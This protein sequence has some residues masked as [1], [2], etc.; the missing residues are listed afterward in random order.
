MKRNRTIRLLR[1]SQTLLSNALTV[2]QELHRVAEAGET[3]EAAP[4]SAATPSTRSLDRS[5]T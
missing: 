5:G 1:A 2:V 4:V 3:S